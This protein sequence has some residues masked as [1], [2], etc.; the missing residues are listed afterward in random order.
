MI[1][2]FTYSN[3]DSRS[4]SQMLAPASK[5]S[6][7]ALPTFPSKTR[8][9]QLTKRSDTI[10]FSTVYS[11]QEVTELFSLAL[12]FPKDDILADDAVNCVPLLVDGSRQW[13]GC[14][15]V[16]NGIVGKFIKLLRKHRSRSAFC[17]K[18]LKIILALCAD[19]KVTHEPNIQRFSDVSTVKV[20][21][22]VLN[23]HVITNIA[24]KQ[25]YSVLLRLI[26]KRW[27]SLNID[28]NIQNTIFSYLYSQK[29]NDVVVELCCKM[30]IVFAS[31]GLTKVSRKLTSTSGCCESLLDVLKSASTPRI[32]FLGLTAIDGIGIKCNELRLISN[33]FFEV[34]I[35]ILKHYKDDLLIVSTGLMI[36]SKLLDFSVSSSSDKKSLFRTSSTKMLGNNGCEMIVDIINIHMKNSDISTYAW[37]IILNMMTRH[38]YFE[39]HS[40]YYPYREIRNSY[41]RAG[42]EIPLD[43]AKEF[44]LIDDTMHKLLKTYIYPISDQNGTIEATSD[45]FIQNELHLLN[46]GV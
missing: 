7:R 46:N 30:I 45:S 11:N 12:L 35:P 16:S 33:H 26:S 21:T 27:Y 37:K 18:A 15:N 8:L 36:V 44:Y 29:Q 17:V 40:Q 34:V 19:K 6:L 39:E 31:S 23:Q 1:K 42:I 43:V 20:I 10:N 32:T 41:Q 38:T 9:H 3:G 14:S 13:L 25:R 2:S 5:K 28:D 4:V 22:L 24:K